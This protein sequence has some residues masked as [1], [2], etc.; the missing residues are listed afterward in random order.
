MCPPANCQVARPPAPSCS[1][2]NAPSVVW[3]LAQR[4]ALHP[5][6][7]SN[8]PLN[9][10]GRSAGRWR[11]GPPPPSCVP[12]RAWRGP[13][14]PRA[15]A[16]RPRWAREAPRAAIFTRPGLHRHTAAPTPTVWRGTGRQSLARP[17]RGRGGRGEPAIAAA[18]VAQPPHPVKRAWGGPASPRVRPK[19]DVAKGG[20]PSP[21]SPSRGLPPLPTG[22]GRASAVAQPPQGRCDQGGRRLP[23]LPSRVLLSPPPGAGKASA[24]PRPPQGQRGQGGPLIAAA[25]IARPPPPPH[26]QGEGQRR[27]AA[28]PRPTWPRGGAPIAAAAIARPPLP[29]HGQGGGPAPSRVRPKAN[30]AAEGR[31]SPLSP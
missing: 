23:S 4:Q 28:V 7:S 11:R 22:K 6:P 3:G 19:A 13:A 2:S 30:V 31:R 9:S 12:P 15:A 25:A 5:A 17:P 29:S 1:L 10:P 16:P 27:R 20:R 14:T 24:V 21:L 26:G 8:P 18:V